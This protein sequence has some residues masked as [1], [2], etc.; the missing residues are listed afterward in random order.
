MELLIKNDTRFILGSV[1]LTNYSFLTISIL[2]HHWFVVNF[3]H[4]IARFGIRSFFLHTENTLL[5]VGFWFAFA[6]AKVSRLSS[7]EVQLQ[8]FI[9]NVRERM[10][11][12][13]TALLCFGRNW[14]WKESRKEERN[15][16]KMQG[17]NQKIKEGNEENL[18]NIWN[19]AFVN[20]NDV[21]YKKLIFQTI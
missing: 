9:Q 5:L 21:S 13:T 7:A 11:I 20:V 19:H 6:R 3:W 4:P 14:I 16:C 10:K 8:V 2:S 18:R 15:S 17:R 1:I 12:Q